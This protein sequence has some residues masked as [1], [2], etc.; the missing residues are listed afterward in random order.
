MK[1]SQ[2]YIICD[3]GS[4]NMRVDI[5][6]TNTTNTEGV[7]ALT[8]CYSGW[9]LSVTGYTFKQ[10]ATSVTITISVLKRDRDEKWW[11]CKAQNGDKKQFKLTVFSEYFNII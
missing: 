10:N 8:T 3:L 2:T 9:C 7:A 5:H 6:K 1:G 11:T 4:T